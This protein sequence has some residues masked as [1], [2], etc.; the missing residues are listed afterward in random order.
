MTTPA[1][2]DIKPAF[3]DRHTRTPIYV[4]VSCCLLCLAAS[5]YIW[6]DRM[7]IGNELIVNADRISDVRRDLDKLENRM[8]R[9]MAWVTDALWRIQ[10]RLGVQPRPLPDDEG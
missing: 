1:S 5:A 2:V 7:A 8:E 9:Q 6:Q 3:I 10:L 4:T